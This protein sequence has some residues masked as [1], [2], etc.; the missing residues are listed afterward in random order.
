MD[1]VPYG[2]EIV[3]AEINLSKRGKW[4]P[5]DVIGFDASNGKHN[6]RLEGAGPEENWTSLGNTKFKW[7]QRRADA[8][9][10]P[11]FLSSPKGE[12]AVGRKVRIFWP[13]RFQRHAVACHIAMQSISPLC[14]IQPSYV[15]PCLMLHRCNSQPHFYTHASVLNPIFNPLA[16]GMGRFYQGVIKSFD[17]ASGMHRVD[18]SDGDSV[19]HE[20]QHE[21][22]VWMSPSDAMTA[23]SPSKDKAGPLR[24]STPASPLKPAVGPH[25]NTTGTLDDPPFSSFTP[26]IAGKK[27]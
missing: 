25:H 18:Y 26:S 13:G 10:N 7:I 9:P 24:A 1:P 5:A 14:S 11:S 19:E 22:V 12:D 17:A 23:A 15:H 27:M 6:L 20:L 8:A 3:G 4:I 21:G 2:L 16:S